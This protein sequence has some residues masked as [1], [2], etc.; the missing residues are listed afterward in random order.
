MMKAKKAGKIPSSINK[1]TNKR[2]LALSTVFEAELTSIVGR[3]I[4]PDLL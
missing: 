3:T 1:K 2:T 4:G